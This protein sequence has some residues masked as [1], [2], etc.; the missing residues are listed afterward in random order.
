M[1][2]PSTIREMLFSILSPAEWKDLGQIR[3][4]IL[5]SRGIS[6]EAERYG[7][8]ETQEAHLN[9]MSCFSLYHALQGLIQEGIAEERT[10]DYTEREAAAEVGGIDCIREYRLQG[11]PPASV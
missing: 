8:L 7:M 6:E 5:S 9:D 2:M 4:G 10:R 11:K 3:Q 1:G